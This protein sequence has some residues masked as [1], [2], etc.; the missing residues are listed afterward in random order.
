MHESVFLSLLTDAGQT[1]RLIWLPSTGFVLP[2]LSSMSSFRLQPSSVVQQQ[3]RVLESAAD[4]YCSGRG[5]STQAAAGSLHLLQR[6]KCDVSSSPII[7]PSAVILATSA[8][9]EAC[10]LLRCKTSQLWQ[11]MQ[12][13]WAGA[14]AQHECARTR[15]SV[16]MRVCIVSTHPCMEVSKLVSEG[17]VKELVWSNH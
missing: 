7:K 17:V 3:G 8:A 16:N 13:P 9:L 11:H 5:P 1:H 4:H 10:P 15:A 14:D 12:V 6:R 2:A